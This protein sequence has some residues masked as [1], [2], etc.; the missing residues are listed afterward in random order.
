MASKVGNRTYN[1]SL[2]VPE[3]RAE[4]VEKRFADHGAWMRETH[5]LYSAADPNYGMLGS[6]VDYYV[7]K[8]PELKNPFDPEEGTTG[9]ILY[10]LNEV[11]TGIAGTEA[12]MAA[13]PYDA[14][15]WD[16]FLASF[17]ASEPRMIMHGEIIQCM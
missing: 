14:S 13:V 15:W 16:P 11:Y 12:H 1:F 2:V 7:S 17:M 5:K 8:S 3:D 6:L 4:E 10:S 9:N